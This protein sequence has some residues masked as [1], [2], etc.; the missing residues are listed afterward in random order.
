M[1]DPLT[2]RFDLGS[3]YSFE[4]AEPSLFAVYQTLYSN[5]DTEM[6]YDW[7]MRLNDTMWTKNCFFLVKDGEKIAGVIA[8][9]SQFIYPC[10]IAPFTDRALFFRLLHRAM[11]AGREPAGTEI[12]AHAILDEDAEILLTMGYT[13]TKHSR[14]VMVRPT[15][16]FEAA[17]PQGFCAVTPTVEQ[18]GEIT[19]L[20][21]R[22]FAN[23]LDA[24][25]IGEITVD[26][27]AGALERAAATGTL[28]VSALVYQENTGM[29]VGACVAGLDPNA[30]N[31][32]A[33]IVELGVLP[34]YQNL[35]LGSFLMKTAL[36]NAH[37]HSAVMKLVVTSGSPAEGL[38]RR[39]GFI[40]GP[41]FTKM[42]FR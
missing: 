6:W 42:V 31:G 7:K 41:R 35:G 34:D 12:A 30:V 17:L 16:R 19:A 40:P 13:R 37:P 3:G 20:L 8:E 39:L 28:P 25:V 32:F 2:D 33:G 24:E 18:A 29:L 1:T 9:K 36:N 26:V 10:V 14:R 22:C 38:Y 21:N 15:D 5:A 27:I 4:R 23:T 11:L